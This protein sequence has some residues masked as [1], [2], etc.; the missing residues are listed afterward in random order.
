MISEECGDE[1]DPPLHLGGALA[2]GMSLLKRLPESPSLHFP[3]WP[4][5]LG[6]LRIRGEKRDPFGQRVDAHGVLAR[7]RELVMAVVEEPAPQGL[8]A[9]LL[10]LAASPDVQSSS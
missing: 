1:V 9:T 3:H 2:L 10:S 8:R 5:V 7:D 6:Q 4:G